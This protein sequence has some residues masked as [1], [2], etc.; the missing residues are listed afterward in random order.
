M[1]FRDIK[2]GLP[3]KFYIALVYFR[4]TQPQKRLFLIAALDNPLAFEVFLG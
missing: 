1:I 4:C 3:G 2:L